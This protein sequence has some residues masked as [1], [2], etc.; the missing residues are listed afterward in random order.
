MSSAPADLA[1]GRR[2]PPWLRVRAPGGP[3]YDEMKALVERQRLH[4]VCERLMEEL[5]FEAPDRSGETVTID[6]QYV[7]ERLEAIVRNAELGRFGFHS[8]KDGAD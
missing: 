8:L 2:H 1:P 6:A 5:S 3:V 7:R 4:T